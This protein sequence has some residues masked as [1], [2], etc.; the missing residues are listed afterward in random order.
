MAENFEKLE[1]EMDPVR[2][3]RAKVKAGEV[4]VEIAREDKCLG[5]DACRDDDVK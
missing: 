2:L 1:R 5:A 4:I 3:A